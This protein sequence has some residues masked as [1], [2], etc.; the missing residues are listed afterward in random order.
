MKTEDYM[1]LTPYERAVIDAL[2]KLHSDLV[3]IEAQLIEL[4]KVDVGEISPS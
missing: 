4:G 3:L 2:Q 1:A